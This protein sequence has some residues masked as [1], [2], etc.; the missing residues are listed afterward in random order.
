MTIIWK[1]PVLRLKLGIS[2]NMQFPHYSPTPSRCTSLI[3]LSQLQK[4]IRAPH[5]SRCDC[6]VCWTKKYLKDCQN[7]GSLS[8]TKE[9]KA[10]ITNPKQNNMFTVIDET[11]G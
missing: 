8:A 9:S 3:S 5:L 6:V 7:S 1:F 11:G 2:M 10:S 4:M